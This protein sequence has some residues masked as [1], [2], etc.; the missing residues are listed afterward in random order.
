MAAPLLAVRQRRPTPSPILARPTTAALLT[1]VL[2]QLVR[3]ARQLV[4]QVLP[5]AR[6]AQSLT[7]ALL[8]LVELAAQVLLVALVALVALAARLASRAAVALVALAAQV[9]M[10]P[11]APVVLVAQVVFSSLTL[12]TAARTRAMPRTTL[13]HLADRVEW[14]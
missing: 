10:P 6:A 13:P 12:Q 9:A 14:Q 2:A 8:V 11:A 1:V 4:A 3:A 5:V 7:L